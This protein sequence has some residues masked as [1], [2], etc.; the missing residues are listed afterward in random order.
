M[1]APFSDTLEVDRVVTCFSFSFINNLQINLAVA[2][3]L[4]EQK[5]EMDSQRIDEVD[6]IRKQM[7][8]DAEQQ[9]KQLEASYEQRYV[10]VLFRWFV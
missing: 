3:A 5:R 7:S 10:T 2:S 1:M 9:R 4:R 8:A 6:G